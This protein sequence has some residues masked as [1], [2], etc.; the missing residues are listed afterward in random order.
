MCNGIVMHRG[1]KTKVKDLRDWHTVKNMYNKGVPIKQIARELKMSKNTVKSLIK[2]EDEPKYSRETRPTKVDKYKDNIRKWYLEKE[3]SFNGTRIY[4]ELCKLGYEGTI[5]PVYRFLETLDDERILISKR[6]SQRFETPP[7]DQAQFDWGEYEV[8]IGARKTKIYCFTMVLSY[9][10]KKAAVCSLTV[11]G[12]AIYEAIQDLFTELGGVTK[13]LLIDNP[14]AL[15]LSHKK[16]EEVVF[17]DAALKLVTYLKTELNACLPLRPRTKGKVEK[18]NQYIE[19]QFIK[20]SSFNS[21][22]ELNFDIKYFMRAWNMKTHGTTRRVPDEM[23]EEEKP[24]LISL[25][26]KLIIDSDL[27]V[28][29][30]STDSFVMIDT[31]RYSIPVKYVDKKVKVRTVY[32]YKL[33]IFDLDLSLIKSYPLLNGKYNRH[34]DPTDYDAIASK[35]PRSIPEIR[36]VFEVTFKH[37]SEFYELASKVTRQAHFHAR[38]FLKLKDLYSV[39]DLDIILKHCVQNNIFKIETMKSVIKEKYLELIIEHDK[40]Q[41]SLLKKNE[42]KHTVRNEK[43]LVR[44]L[45][46]YGK[47]DNFDS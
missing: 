46:Y 44:H 29:T 8:Y 13:E 1:G 21:M 4:N 17:N 6:A 47:G 3:Y 5:N 38:E 9:S 16:G 33:E 31:N 23:F 30:V 27:E 26:D 2:K 15:V 39:E 11:N 34:E 28:R 40:T 37:G 25:R 10:R 43:E 41:L 32:G 14:K 19:E 24:L 35:I 20:G 18:P 7:G 12:S 45:S 36:R 22:E 42:N